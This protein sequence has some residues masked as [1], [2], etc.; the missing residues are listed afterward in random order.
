M[1]KFFFFSS[2]LFFKSFFCRYLLGEVF[3]VVIIF[4]LSFVSLVK[5]INGDMN[6]DV[7]LLLPFIVI[8]V[9]G[10]IDGMNQMVLLE[11]VR[12]WKLR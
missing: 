11:L 7:L 9:C 10:D 2:D 6:C 1:F 12:L 5:K 8:F 3:L 4:F